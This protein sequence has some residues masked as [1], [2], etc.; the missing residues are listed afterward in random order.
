MKPCI[1]LLLSATTMRPCSFSCTK[2][3]VASYSISI[4]AL[5]D[6][7]IIPKLCSGSFKTGGRERGKTVLRAL[8]VRSWT[9]ICVGYSSYHDFKNN[10]VLRGQ[11]IKAYRKFSPSFLVR[12]TV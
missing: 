12:R 2:L 7:A 11:I 8:S 1:C 5:W 9:K 10:K 3:H 4:Y 6:E